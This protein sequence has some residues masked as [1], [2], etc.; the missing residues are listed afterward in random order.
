MKDENI[1]LQL[2][3]LKYKFYKQKM[4][5]NIYNQLDFSYILEFLF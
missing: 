1:Y 3:F 4:K 5:N 2:F